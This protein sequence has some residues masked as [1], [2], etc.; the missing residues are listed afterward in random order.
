MERL[1][2]Y[3]YKL[4]MKLGIRLTGVPDMSADEREIAQSR[5]LQILEEVFGGP[6]G[7]WKR[8]ECATAALRVKDAG[9]PLGPAEVRDL[10]RWEEAHAVAAKL[11]LGSVTTHK[12]AACFGLMRLD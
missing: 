9:Q 11:A 8:H 6:E 2:F 5:Y 4:F 7:V 1:L 10:K 3:P 12:E